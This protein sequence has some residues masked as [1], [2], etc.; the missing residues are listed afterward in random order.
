MAKLAH[1]EA[2]RLLH[3]AGGDMLTADLTCKALLRYA[4]ALTNQQKSDVVSIPVIG[5]GGGMVIAHLLLGPSS[6]LYSTPVNSDVPDPTDVEIV[7]DL[8]HRTRLL[9]PARPVW[10]SEMQDILDFDLDSL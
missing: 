3:Y 9:E 2:M 4:R 7:A 6:Q 1:I 10:S 5:M 8:E